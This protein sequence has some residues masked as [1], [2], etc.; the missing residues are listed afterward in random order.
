MYG[1]QPIILKLPL[2]VKSSSLRGTK[3]RPPQPL[4][5]C[6]HRSL[7]CPLRGNSSVVEEAR[8]TH[9][10]TS[11]STPRFLSSSHTSSTRDKFSYTLRLCAPWGSPIAHFPSNW[12]APTFH[13]ANSLLDVTNST[14]NHCLVKVQDDTTLHH[15]RIHSVANKKRLCENQK[16]ITFSCQPHANLGPEHVQHTLHR[17]RPFSSAVDDLDEVISTEQ[18]HDTSKFHAILHCHLW[19]LQSNGVEFTAFRRALP[20]SSLTCLQEVI[21]GL[22]NRCRSS[23]DSW[24]SHASASEHKLYPEL[25]HFSSAIFG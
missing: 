12:M 16:I 5:K 7:S 11:L 18:T 2:N 19:P 3:R 20:L 24:A 8:K 4:G 22:A 6:A 10:M 17:I 15:R 14:L 13:W 21:H 9:P 23:A 25:P 1:K